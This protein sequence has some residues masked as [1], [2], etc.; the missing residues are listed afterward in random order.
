MDHRASVL[1]FLL[2]IA[3]AAAQDD[4]PMQTTQHVNENV[5]YGPPQT[6]GGF[7]YTFGNLQL[8]TLRDACPLFV[9]Y[10]PPHDLA[11]PSPNRTM[12]DVAAQM[13]ITKVTFRCVTEWLLVL[14]IGSTCIADR[15][16]VVGQVPQLVT[17]PCPPVAPSARP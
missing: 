16:F 1:S 4:C 10:T 13:P 14:P 2:C 17:R 8:S 6:C 3:P 7:T 5:T 12:V 9:V 11:V 15:T